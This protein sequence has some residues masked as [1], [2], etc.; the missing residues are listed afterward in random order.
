[1]VEAKASQGEKHEE[2]DKETAVGV[3]ISS[4]KCPDVARLMEFGVH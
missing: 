1:M 3:A 4:L 2:G